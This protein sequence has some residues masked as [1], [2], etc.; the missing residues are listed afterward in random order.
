MP[1]NPRARPGA[2]LA[3][4]T[5]MRSIRL[6]W[7]GLILVG[8][9]S[10]CAPSLKSAGSDLAKGVVP[11]AMDSEVRK[12]EEQQI[13]ERVLAIMN[14]PEMQKTLESMAA[15]FAKGAA[16]GLTRDEM[17]QRYREIATSI[18]T[19]ASRVAVDAMLEESTSPA[20]Q[21]RL[22]ELMAMASAAATRSAIQAMAE[23]MPRTLGPAFE[24]M[25]HDSVV[26]TVEHMVK[27]TDAH[28]IVGSLAFEASR[29]AVLGSNE[30]MAELEQKRD[31]EG[32]LARLT[33]LF[34]HRWVFVAVAVV[35]LGM[36]GLLLGL[37]LHTR[38][39]LKQVLIERNVEEDVEAKPRSKGRIH[40]EAPAH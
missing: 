7:F 30:G 8:I 15:G 25:L 16:E 23:E 12:L 1:S 28:S 14:S 36:F 5:A 18:A 39:Q 4:L 32:L 19:V 33:D 35:V 9:L 22:A 2:A 3:R 21:R 40:R 10:G 29:Q 24:Q 13:R 26:P 37:L 27:D 6:S 17:A 20:N 34:A 31:K 11:S 38:S